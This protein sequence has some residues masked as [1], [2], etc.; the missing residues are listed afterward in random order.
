MGGRNLRNRL[1]QARSDTARAVALSDGVFA[2]VIT[3]LA[4]DL[5]AP[6]ADP[7]GL[8]P[9]LLA[10]WPAYLAFVT[11]F[12]YVAVVWLN[13]KAAFRRIRWMSPGLHWANLSILLTTAL[14]PFPTSV[15]AEVMQR[16]NTTDA[17][18]AVGLYALVGVMLCG[19]WLVFFGHLGRHPELLRQ[20]GDE[21]F[22]ANETRRAWAGVVGYTL[23]GV[24][25]NAV[26]PGVASVLF[27][28]LPVFYGAT[29]EGLYDERA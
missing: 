28:A 12:L 26:S 21:R 13:H 29:F 16:A 1:H 18:A 2:I 11:S 6:E 15:L 14:L 20:E 23:A 24:L 8:L 10:Q 5:R 25:G 3:L 19:S 7:G 4:I 9:G 27:L 22:F 17:R